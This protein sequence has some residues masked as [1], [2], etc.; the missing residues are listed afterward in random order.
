[1][2]R[3]IR[4][5]SA[6]TAAL[7]ALPRQAQELNSQHRLMGQSAYQLEFL[8]G[9]NVLFP[10][11]HTEKSHNLSSNGHRHNERG[12]D[13]RR[14]EPLHHGPHLRMIHGI[15]HPISYKEVSGP[16]A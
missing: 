13:S 10:E 16:S 6:T 15:S 12:H 2:S 9:K 14:H 7:Q 3:A 11:A 4:F 5:R 1:M 8:A